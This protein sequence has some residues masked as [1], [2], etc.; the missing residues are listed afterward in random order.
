[1]DSKKVSDKGRELGVDFIKLTQ[2]IF[3]YK[4]FIIFFTMF[5]VFCTAI[6]IFKKPNEYISYTSVM[7][8][9]ESSGVGGLSKYVGLA[10]LAGIDLGSVTK[11]EAIRPDLYPDIINNTSFF[12]NLLNQ[13]IQTLDNKTIGFM[14]FYCNAYK[15]DTLEKNTFIDVIK[16]YLNI[17]IKKTQ[18]FS[19]DS[20]KL[21][22][23]S[24]GKSKI[25]KEVSKRVVANMD[26]K[27]GII[28]VQVELPDPVAAAYVA[29][30]SMDYLTSFV[31]S[32][33]TNKASK[34]VDF[35][36]KRLEEAKGKYYD[37]QVKKARY[38]D[39]YS[40]PTIRL[41]TADIQR[42]RIESDFRVNSTFY[43]ELLKQY[44]SAKLKL[45]QET[46]VFKTLQKPVIPNEKKGPKRL[47]ILILSMFLAI[48]CSIIILV[49]KYNS[50]YNI[51]I[52]N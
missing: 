40:L 22:Y 6:V 42:E 41:Q 50:S 27:T 12:L 9:Y 24:S 38:S 3:F 49:L 52:I 16:S 36:A 7:P 1:M 13:K 5:F 30:I 35:L 39:E 19:I 33:R 28:S 11:S 23:V 20:E 29:S 47:M 18:M 10:S 51:L 37:T 25:I 4:W 14:D 26:K 32:Y 45:Y 2:L 46:P 21:V 34:D 48:F 15:I 8:E 43:Q 44:E 31:S 17:N